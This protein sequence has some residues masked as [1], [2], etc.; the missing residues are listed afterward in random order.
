MGS[1]RTTQGAAVWT[2]HAEKLEKQRPLISPSNVRSKRPFVGIDPTPYYPYSMTGSARNLRRPRFHI[3]LGRRLCIFGVRYNHEL[4]AP[5]KDMPVNYGYG[6]ATDLR[7][8]CHIVL[9]PLCPS[10]RMSRCM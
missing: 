6:C 4:G 1:C 9:L 10:A 3:V 2:A 8:I 7:L 5:V